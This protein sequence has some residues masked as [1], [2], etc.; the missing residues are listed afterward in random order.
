MSFPENLKRINEIIPDLVPISAK[1]VERT[2]TQSRRLL[3]ESSWNLKPLQPEH[4]YT[5]PFRI[6]AAV[7]RQIL[8][9]SATISFS[10]RLFSVSGTVC[11]FNRGRLKPA[12]IDI[13]TTLYV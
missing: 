10:E 6:L 3:S 7:A 8:G 11:T 5:Q 4:F 2:T 12:N 9:V 1:T 13:V